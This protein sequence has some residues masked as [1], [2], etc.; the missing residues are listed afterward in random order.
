[1]AIG[2]LSLRLGWNTVAALVLPT[3]EEWWYPAKNILLSSGGRPCHLT[4]PP[5]SFPET[6]VTRQLGG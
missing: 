6:L 2:W 4:F 3:C 1:M 5:E